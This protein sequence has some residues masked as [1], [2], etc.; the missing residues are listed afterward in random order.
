LGVRQV[1]EEIHRRWQVSLSAGRLRFW[2]RR[3]GWRWKRVRKSLKKE[4]D[5]GL[6]RFF[7]AEIKE[8]AA[9][10]QAGEIELF[11]YDESGFDLNPSPVRAWHR[12]GSTLC[13]PAR[14]GGALTVAGFLSRDNRLEAYSLDGPM[15]ADWFIAFMDDFSKDRPKKT[16]VLLDQAP[17]HRSAKVAA[18]IE[19]W[20]KRG[21]F[22]Q[23]IPPYSPE[24]NWIEILWRTIKHQWLP[25]SAYHSLKT[26]DNALENIFLNYGT[27][28]SIEFD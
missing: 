4:R 1:K 7:E 26:L 27:K 12:P 11:S 28:Y 3:W 9:L 8:L 24:L 10:E 16:V 13:L 14:R 17:F 18:R 19:Q 22:L 6:F 20:K 2:L 21:L 23:F 25:I 5:E 15:N